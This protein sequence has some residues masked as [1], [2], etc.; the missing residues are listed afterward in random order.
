[1]AD[2]TAWCGRYTVNVEIQRGSIP[3]S[4]ATFRMLTATFNF[5]GI[6]EKMHPVLLCV[7]SSVG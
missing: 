3:L 5:F 7:C 6:K 2:G 4:V 1:M